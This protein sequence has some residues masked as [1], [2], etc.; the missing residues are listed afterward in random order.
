MNDWVHNY[1]ASWASYE[2]E[3]G[4]HVHIISVHMYMLTKGWQLASKLYMY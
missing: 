4:A 3:T 1:D 2:S